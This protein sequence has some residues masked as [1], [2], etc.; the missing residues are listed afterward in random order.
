MKKNVIKS[1]FGLGAVL[2]VLVIVFSVSYYY[3][4]VHIPVKAELS[5]LQQIAGDYKS[6]NGNFG[7]IQVS[8][9][10][11][12]NLLNQNELRNCFAG[13]TF[14]KTPE[15][16]EVLTSPDIENISC[17]F[18]VSTSTGLVED[19][20]VTIVRKEKAYCEDSVGN[21]L[22]TPGLTTTHKCDGNI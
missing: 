2:L 10:N 6:K 4:S 9:K 8:N 15:A 14:V 7:I 18:K 3:T 19:W 5:K 22:E 20:S 16:T 21:R 12:N 1:K 13:N 11:K 17:V